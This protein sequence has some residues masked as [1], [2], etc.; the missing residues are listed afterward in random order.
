[1]N[2]RKSFRNESSAETE[3]DNKIE[4]LTEESLRGLTSII[5]LV[6]ELEAAGTTLST[7]NKERLDEVTRILKHASRRIHSLQK[8]KQPE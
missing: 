7:K 4:Q 8:E 3:Q 1:M 2:E 5:E 6:Q